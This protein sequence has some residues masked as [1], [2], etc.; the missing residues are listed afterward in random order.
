MNRLYNIA[1]LMLHG[2]FESTKGI[3]VIIQLDREASRNAAPPKVRRLDPAAL[4]GGRATKESLST[5]SARSEKN[6]DSVEPK[7][8]YKIT[9]RVLQCCGL[10]LGIFGCSMFIFKLA[11]LPGLY[12]LLSHLFANSA[13][14]STVW[15]WISPSLSVLFHGLWVVP[16]YVISKVVNTLW[17]QDIADSAYKIRKG[18]PQLITSI[19]KF[20]ADSAINFVIQLLFLLQSVLCLI[21]PFPVPFLGKFLYIIHMSMLCSL[22]AFEYKWLN[23]GWELHKRLTYIENNWPFF[24]GFGLPLAILSELAGA[25]FFNSCIFSALF[26]LLIV[27]ANETTPRVV[28]GERPLRLFAVV[29]VITNLVLNNQ[30]KLGKTALTTPISG[31]PGTPALMGRGITPPL[32]SGT[33]TPSLN[34]QLNQQQKNRQHHHHHRQHRRTSPTSSTGTD[35]MAGTVLSYQQQ[36]QALLNRNFRR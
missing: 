22:Y 31:S 32:S 36:Q 5:P 30:I 29:V 10:S 13:T 20:I 6:K 28:V 2:A 19:S 25:F 12:Y 11:V 23:M 7:I 8:E 17:F 14:A 33:P 4:S 21:I 3:Y 9:R 26:S 35:S 18:R 27:S 15:G 34:F 24:I 1:I 16:L